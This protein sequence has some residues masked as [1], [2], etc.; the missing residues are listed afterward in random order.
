MLLCCEPGNGHRVRDL[1]PA[2]GDAVPAQHRG[3]AT[4]PACQ[5]RGH[6]RLLP[7]ELHREGLRPLPPGARLRPVAG[8]QRVKNTGTHYLL[9]QFGYMFFSSSGVSAS[10]V[11]VV[12][13]GAEILLVPR[14]TGGEA[15]LRR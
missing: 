7:Q 5:R 12:S 1:P 13:R 15:K 2:A 6:P 14:G 10:V 3:Q 11:I 8:V 9:H 4:V